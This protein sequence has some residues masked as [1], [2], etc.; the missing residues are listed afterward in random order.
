MNRC[1]RCAREIEK[2]REEQFGVCTGPLC[3][4]CWEE[5][6]YCPGHTD[7]EHARTWARPNGKV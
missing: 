6:G 5:F 1:G 2:G 4:A 3:V 7:E